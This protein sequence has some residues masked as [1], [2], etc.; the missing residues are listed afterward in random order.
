MPSE[1]EGKDDFHCWKLIWNKCHRGV[2]MIG[3]VAPRPGCWC[4]TSTQR[5]P[6]W[7]LDPC[8]SSLQPQ[9]T[10]VLEP[11]P[12]EIAVFLCFHLGA[13]SEHWLCFKH[14]SPYLV[15]SCC[16]RHWTPRNWSPR[17]FTY[18]ISILQVQ[19]NPG[20]QIM[21]SGLCLLYFIAFTFRK[22]L[23]SG[24]LGV[25]TGSFRLISPQF[26]NS[27]GNKPTVFILLE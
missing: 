16:D 4:K 27:R 18:S 19:M 12:Q 2:R 26:N 13:A 8:P 24:G 22:A 20:A 21:P 3:G 14:I 17:F 5:C 1:K 25:G 23:P 15:L 7:W 9:P 11:L 10:P 6:E